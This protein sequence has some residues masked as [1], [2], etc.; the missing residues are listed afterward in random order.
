MAYFDY[1]ENKNQAIQ[2]DLAFAQNYNKLSMWL[3]IASLAVFI[4]DIIVF[5]L[6]PAGKVIWLDILVGAGLIAGIIGVVYALKVRGMAKQKHNKNPLANF[7]A[8]WGL[9]LVLLQIII[10]VIN[11]W[12]Y[13]S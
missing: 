9:L 7:L 1:L 8:V 11:T 2:K 12:V 10:L 3:I 6:V 4:I 13:F 5:C